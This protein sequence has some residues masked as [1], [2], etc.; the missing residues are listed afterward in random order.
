MGV[1]G[2]IGGIPKDWQLTTEQ[3]QACNW[4]TDEQCPVVAGPE[5]NLRFV[6][7]ID[8]LLPAVSSPLVETRVLQLAKSVFKPRENRKKKFSVVFSIFSG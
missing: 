3:E 6:L 8:P 4:L 7:P 2:N 5:Y 1:L